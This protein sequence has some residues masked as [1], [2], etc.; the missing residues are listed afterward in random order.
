MKILCVAMA[1]AA[2]NLTYAAGPEVGAGGM[3]AAWR[4][5][6]KPIVTPPKYPI[7][8]FGLP[9]GPYSLIRQD[10]QP[11]DVHKLTGKPVL[12]N[13]V[14]TECTTSCA[15]TTA[16]LVRTYQD[17]RDKKLELQII[18]ITVNPLGDTPE[19]LKKYAANMGADHPD[20]HW[21]T[22]RPEVVSQVMAHYGVLLGGS[23]PNNHRNGIYLI[24]RWGEVFN[25]FPT[26]AYDHAR[27]IREIQN[28]NK[29]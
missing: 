19:R 10:G 17:A 6:V 18:S 26:G 27:M 23:N 12:L 9:M 21:V 15:P 1:L 13:F 22:G 25:E 8:P 7:N 4:G 28:M 14:F 11:L 2:T 5:I 29:F 24:N 16:N 20:W 3:S